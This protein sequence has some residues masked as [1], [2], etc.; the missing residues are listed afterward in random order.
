MEVI[1]RAEGL[2]KRY[3]RTVA[4]E[5]TQAEILDKLTALGG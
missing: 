1:V 4:L 5:R 2:T 3:G